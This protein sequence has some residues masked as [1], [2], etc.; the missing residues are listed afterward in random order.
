M[1]LGDDSFPAGAL[2]NLKFEYF[3]S[4]IANSVSVVFIVLDLA[5]VQH[6]YHCG[7]CS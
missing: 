6:K 1:Q 5:L 3:F 2:F 4:I 7:V